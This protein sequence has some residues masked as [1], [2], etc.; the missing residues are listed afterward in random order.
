MKNEQRKKEA[1]T[2]RLR[3]SAKL[4]RALDLS[5]KA[6]LDLPCIEI[7]ADNRLSVENYKG[8]LELNGDLIR[9]YT[10]LGILRIE[11][12]DMSV[13]NAD[14]QSILIDG[15]ITLVEYEDGRC[16]NG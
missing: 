11:G 14:M 3:K 15:R 9:L 12:R 16:K 13:R 2:E 4:W 7:C 5:E 6:S 10:G 1:K 8:V